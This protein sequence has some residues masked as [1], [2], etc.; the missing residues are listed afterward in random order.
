MGSGVLRVLAVIAGTAVI[1]AATHANVV[2][3]GGYGSNDAA[4]IIAIAALLAVGMGFVSATFAEGRRLSA[5]LLGICILS[6]ETYWVLL[7][8]EREF[9][10]R[11][12]LTAPVA[13]AQRKY[14]DA[15]HRV[16]TAAQAK[17]SADA[18][19]ISEAAKRDC[20]S[21]CAN[22]LLDARDR[23]DAEL[24]AARSA[25]AAMPVPPS[26]VPLPERLGIASWAW[27]LIMAASRA[28]A[29]LGGS[30]AI[31]LAL[32]GC[33]ERPSAPAERRERVEIVEP[34]L[35]KREHVARFLHAVL[36]PDPD[37]HASLRALHG[38]YGDWCPTPQRL[39]PAE[40]GAEL[41]AILEVLG[42]RCEKVANDV[43]VHGATICDWS[44]T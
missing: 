5:I 25:L 33:R 28:L 11:D 27:D 8:A 14:S 29:V 13:E 31:G 15:Q 6:G 21:N 17:R 22:L 19:A 7:N 12:A 18:A 38:R 35:A 24:A 41:R 9:V 44:R 26:A 3:A 36:R 1:A 40:L 43:V 20:A 10:A 42:L 32:H 16:E 23:A 39:P 37:G 30:L 4:L 34:P 2:H